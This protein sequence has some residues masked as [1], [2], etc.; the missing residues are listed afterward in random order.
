MTQI[1]PISSHLQYQRSNFN[2]RFQGTNIQTIAVIIWRD[3]QIIQMT[4]LR[5]NGFR[6]CWLP[7]LKRLDFH[8]TFTT[9]PMV[10]LQLLFHFSQRNP[11]SFYFFSEKDNFLSLKFCYLSLLAKKILVPPSSPSS[12][13]HNPPHLYF[14]FLSMYPGKITALDAQHI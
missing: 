12:M 14:C 3:P 9:A 5:P 8:L 10:S 6:V 11:I 2:M 1:P 7:Q 13:V 4:L